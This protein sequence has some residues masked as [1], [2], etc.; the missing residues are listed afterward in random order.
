MTERKPVNHQEESE[1]IPKT[2]KRELLEWAMYLLISVVLALA[3]VHGLGRFTVVDGNS[4]QPTLQN[5]DVVIVESLTK[6]FQGIQQGD[7]VVA[8]IPELLGG[9]RAYAVK[10]VIAVAGQRV[11]IAN[12][13]VLVDGSALS[14]P[15]VSGVSTDAAGSPHADMVVPE[16]CLYLLGD[17]RQPEKSRDSRTFGVVNSDRVVGKA[18][19]RLFPFSRFGVFK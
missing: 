8:R 10:R 12:G 4:M 16:G 6:R 17:N 7:I 19:V 14:E 3:I 9:R 5:R 15:Y 1:Q 18:F 2:L 11:Q 13:Q